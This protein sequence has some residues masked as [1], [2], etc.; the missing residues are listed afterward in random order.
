MKIFK[1]IERYFKHPLNKAARLFFNIKNK[2]GKNNFVYIIDKNNKKHKTRFYQ[3]VLIE[4]SGT[5][6]VVEIHESSIPAF[7]NCIFYINGNNNFV[8]FKKDA[9][10][11]HNIELNIKGDNS[12]LIAGSALYCGRVNFYIY[13]NSSIIIGNNCM[14]SF[15]VYI[16]TTDG[17]GIY[18]ENKNLINPNRDVIIGNHVWICRGATVLKGACIGDESVLGNFSILTKDY[19]NHQ[20]CIL[21]GNP[22]KIVKENINWEE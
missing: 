15:D 7:K 18:D 3:F 19:S 11:L 21:A 12:K 8:S 9:R 22:A 13:G 14:F 1:K 4:F 16:W 10:G 6:N 2:K 20:H 17:H 5:N